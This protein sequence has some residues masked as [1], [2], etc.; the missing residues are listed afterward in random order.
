MGK[1]GG[2]GGGKRKRKR[3]NDD[4]DEDFHCSVSVEAKIDEDNPMADFVDIMTGMEVEKPAISPYGHV[5]GYETWTMLLRTSKHKNVCPF[6]MQKLTRRSLVKLTK[7]NYEEYKGQ[8][9]NIS[10]AEQANMGLMK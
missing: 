8:I 6:T 9:K 4:D 1:K 2:K 10:A 3:K 5:L 7:A